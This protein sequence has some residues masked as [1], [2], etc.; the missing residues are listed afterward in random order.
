MEQKMPSLNQFEVGAKVKGI[1]AE[2]L[3]V[4]L[5]SVTDATLVIEDLNATSMDIVAITIAIDDA[6]D[7]GFELDSLPQESVSVLWIIDYVMSRTTSNVDD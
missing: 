6:F 2:S 4:P 7:F 5:A 1:I 3:A